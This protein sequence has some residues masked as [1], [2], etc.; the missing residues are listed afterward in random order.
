ME[1][2]QS[3]LNDPNVVAMS[4]SKG[5]TPHEYLSLILNSNPTALAPTTGPA[6]AVQDDTPRIGTVGFQDLGPRP[7][8][9]PPA[10][11]T[12]VQDNQGTY[13]TFGNDNRIPSGDMNAFVA[14]TTN[15][16]E[17]GNARSQEVLNGPADRAMAA[18]AATEDGRPIGQGGVLQ[19]NQRVGTVGFQDPTQSPALSAGGQGATSG[20]LTSGG[21]TAA[22]PRPNAGPTSGA[23]QTPT[24]NTG[25]ARQ[26]GMPDMRIGRMAQLG[27]MGT[28]MLGSAGNGLLAS[29]SA[30]GEAMYAVNDENR[31]AEMGEYENSE[32]LRLE[33]AQRRAVAARG[34]SGGGSGGAGGPTNVAG[35]G[36]YQRATLTALDAIQG[37]IDRDNGS[38]NPYNNIN[39]F[40]GN[41]LAARPGTPAH[42]VA[43][44]LNTVEGAIGFDRLDAM[45]KASKTGGALGAISEREL[46]LLSSSLA[47]LRQSASAEDFQRNIT[48]VRT[49][50]QSAVAALDAQL[51]VDAGLPPAPT[52]QPTEPAFNASDYTVVEITE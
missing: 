45:R 32:R 48:L 8:V 33:E 26:S 39:G 41:W 16:V 9:R 31:A 20:A 25:N 42:D 49:H 3:L 24:N 30:G 35:G 36:V 50:Y 44:L 40:T 23:R 29:M 52:G 6:L 47:S 10:L 46:A 11:A 15:L 43:G 28:A 19:N 2:P 14:G 21:N 37:Y 22:A 27:R 7:D 18:T 1:F 13:P 38:S 51:A 34:G 17:A 4:R 12:P 5:Q